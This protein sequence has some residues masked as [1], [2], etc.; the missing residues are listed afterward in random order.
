[1]NVLLV[2]PD[3]K[4]A[5]MYKTAL[6]SAGHKVFWA[7]DAQSAVHLADDSAP[8][9]V[10]LEIQLTSHSGIEFLYEFR[11]YNEWQDIPDSYCFSTLSYD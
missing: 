4:L 7:L 8:D 9:L 5:G 11:S 3:T 2:E 10:V 1:M 6:E